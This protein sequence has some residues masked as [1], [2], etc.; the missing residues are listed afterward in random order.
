[1]F[2]FVFLIKMM[3]I[4]HRVSNTFKQVFSVLNYARKTSYPK[5]R[6]AL[7]YFDE[8][9]PSRLDYGK[10]KFGG[11][12]SDEEVEDVRTI[13][14]LLPFSLCMIVACNIMKA[15]SEFHQHMVLKMSTGFV[16]AI[17]VFINILVDSG[18]VTASIVPLIYIPVFLFIIQPLFYK[19]IPSLLKRVG[20]GIFL[21][22]VAFTGM[23]VIDITGHAMDNS[24]HCMFTVNITDTP[25][26]ISVYYYGP[27]SLTHYFGIV[28]IELYSLEFLIAQAPVKMNGFVIGLWY[29]CRSFSHLLSIIILATFTKYYPKTSIPFPSCG[30]A[31]LMAFLV[32]LIIVT[33]VYFIFAKWYKLRERDKEVNIYAIVTEHYEKYLDQEKEYFKVN[34]QYQ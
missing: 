12:F 11:P 5:R 20:I 31:Y 4:S 23:L 29:S 13:L 24:A 18:F 6:S 30:T 2:S 7:T 34:P 32:L 28:L 33:V 25:I 9:E 27:F 14:H 26:P 15:N 17:E 10:E 19:Y 3:D 8:E 21:R 1:M 16:Y 22:L